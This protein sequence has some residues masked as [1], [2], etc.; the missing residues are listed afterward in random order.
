VQ[1]DTLIRQRCHRLM[2]VSPTPMLRPIKASLRQDGRVHS[3]HL[4]K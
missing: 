1:F 4:P 2:L 3:Q